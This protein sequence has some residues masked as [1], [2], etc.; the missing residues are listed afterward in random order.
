MLMTNVML[1]LFIFPSGAMWIV[2]SL[3][4]L[5]H[6]MVSFVDKNWFSSTR[7][8]KEQRNTTE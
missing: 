6:T 2:L 7:G 4:V 5:H 3:F 1:A 8:G